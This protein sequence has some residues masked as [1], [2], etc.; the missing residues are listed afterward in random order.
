MDNFLTKLAVL[1]MLPLVRRK[2]FL[3]ECGVI[4]T[5]SVDVVHGPS[6][7]KLVCIK[8]PATVFVKP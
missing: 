8:L 6:H 2:L 1:K 4:E 7:P 3:I 5:I